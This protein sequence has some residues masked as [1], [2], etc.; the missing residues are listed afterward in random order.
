MDKNGPKI[1]TL[2]WFAFILTLVAFVFNFTL[3][4]KH[5]PVVLPNGRN[6]EYELIKKNTTKRA[7]SKKEDVS[8]K[9]KPKDGVNKVDNFESTN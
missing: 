1:V 6:G 2:L 9:T 7:V 3:L 8:Q 5:K 4:F